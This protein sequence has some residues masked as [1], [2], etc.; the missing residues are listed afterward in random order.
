MV[1]A[2]LFTAAALFGST[3]AHF[4]LVYPPTRGFE[5]DIEDQAPC[6][7]F[8]NVTARTPFPI[9]DSKIALQSSHDA[10]ILVMISF[11]ESPSNITSFTTQANGQPRNPVENWFRI[12][13]K[14][15][16]R[17][18]DIASGNYTEAV[19]GANATLLV[20]YVGG[21]SPLF[22]CSDI[23]L[24]TNASVPNNLT[25]TGTTSENTSIPDHHSSTA[26]ST[27]TS[28]PNG[29]NMLSC[30]IGSVVASAVALTYLLV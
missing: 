20:Q 22:Q 13:G 17:D 11:A 12:S 6:G 5:H 29:A 27:A 25:C 28:T 19:D 15:V 23:V 21:D 14:D 26:T 18:I 10:N 9:G 24:R 4:S 3:F 1:L 7:G 8:N 16:C 30:A 2:S